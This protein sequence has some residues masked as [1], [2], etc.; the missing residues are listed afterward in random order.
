MEVFDQLYEE[1]AA[2]MM[3]K[4]KHMQCYKT[5]FLVRMFNQKLFISIVGKYNNMILSV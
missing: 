3:Q 4:D 5:Y 1:Y 2:L